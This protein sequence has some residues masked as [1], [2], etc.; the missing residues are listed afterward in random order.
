MSAE[1]ATDS[2][3]RPGILWWL[4]LLSCPLLLLLNA[5][6]MVRLFDWVSGLPGIE[7]QALILALGFVILPL[8]I[9]ALVAA[10]VAVRYVRYHTAAAYRTQISG[11][12]NRQNYHQDLV[13]LIADN[14]PGATIIIDAE[15][16]LWFVNSQAA[17]RMN[18]PAAD[19]TGRVFEKVFP[20]SDVLRINAL[21]QDMQHGGKPVDAISK[22]SR[23][24]KT[25][26]VQTH[27]VPLP[28]ITNMTGAVMINED[29]IT[30]L[31]VERE[32]RERM[33]RQVIDTL[34]AIVDRRDPF[35]SGHSAR[36]GQIA[37]ALAE[38]LQLDQTQ[39]ETAEIA[40]LLMNFGKVLVPRDILVKTG[41]LSAEELKQVHDGLLSSAD[42]L[43]LIGF[44][45][46]VV[47]TL[48]QALERYDGSGVPNG[49]KGEAILMT[50]RIV[51]VAN[52]FVALLSARAHRAGMNVPGA[53]EALRHNAGK[54]Y[55]ARV[56]DA[57]TA[58]LAAHKQQLEWLP[59]A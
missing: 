37:R 25:C 7:S 40:G 26:Y 30:N 4:L 53:I 6:A 56:V 3:S 29:D 50:A 36:V 5:T 17:Q 48:R 9:F 47:P 24:G 52:A 33:F 51:A 16:R 21:L 28:D 10:L 34:V 46:P 55:D 18:V 22:I 19:V 39:V 49:L 59:D 2:Q 27:L 20:E 43:A 35:A 15:H 31:L 8:L 1:S 13:R 38:Q 14:R 23:D 57:L 45:Q 12:T 42:I 54:I 58:C 11:L 32:A 44:S 41:V